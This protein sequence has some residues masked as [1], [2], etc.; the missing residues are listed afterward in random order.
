MLIV[1]STD[2]T[3]SRA[4]RIASRGSLWRITIREFG[5]NLAS[6]SICAKFCA[7]ETVHGTGCSD[8]EQRVFAVL[9][10]RGRLPIPLL[11]QHTRITPKHLRH[12]LAVLVQQNLVYHYHDPDSK[13]TYYEANADAAY[14]LVRSGKILRILKSRYGNLAEDVVQNLLLL[15]HTRV[16][17]LQ[18]AY[19]SKAPKTQVNGHTNGETTNGVNG[20]YKKDQKPTQSQLNYAMCQL[21][22]AGFIE[23]VTEGMF[24][25]PADTYNLIEKEIL[26]TKFGGGTKGVKQKEELKSSIRSRLSDLRDDGKDW[27][28][29]CTGYKGA[30]SSRA[31]FGMDKR[32]KLDNGIGTNGTDVVTLDVGL[33][34]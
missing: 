18:D 24:R 7:V 25:S 28:P 33:L 27:R 9:L 15:G 22:E 26:Q 13:V 29:Y 11:I 5:T 1:H 8:S 17:D 14:S 21:L 31:Q 3:R 30:A 6:R 23:P 20:D 16:G 10:R 32:R 12:G 4:L 19:S 34:G 2:K